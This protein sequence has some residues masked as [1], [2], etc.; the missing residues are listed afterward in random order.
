MKHD[1][2]L[3]TF[4][5]IAPMMYNGQRYAPEGEV[6]PGRNPEGQVVLTTIEL[7]NVLEAPLIETL[8]QSGA[9]ASLEGE[10]A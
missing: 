5:V 8:K 6:W 3:A 9:I 1:N 4:K 2:P 10:S 7:H